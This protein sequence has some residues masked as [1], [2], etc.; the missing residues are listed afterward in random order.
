M[1]SGLCVLIGVPP[2]MAMNLRSS[3]VC[4][5]RASTCMQ[6]SD[7]ESCSDLRTGNK[8]EVGKFTAGSP[9]EGADPLRNILHVTYMS[10]P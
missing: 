9:E 2:T 5:C 1:L 7:H 10:D 8:T 6:S 3:C 4:F